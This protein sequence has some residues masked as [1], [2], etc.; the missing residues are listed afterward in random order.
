MFSSSCR[1]QLQLPLTIL[2]CA[3]GS[4]LAG[5]DQERITAGPSAEVPEPSVSA[6]GSSV[7]AGAWTT[8]APLPTP[9]SN[10]TAGVVND[11]LGQPILYVLGGRSP[12]I[13]Q[14]RVYAY[15]ATTNKWTE[16]A[17]MPGRRADMNGAATIKGMLY[18]SGGLNSVGGYTNTL[19]VY[20][21]KANAWATKAP[22]PNSVVN[23]I[24][25][26]L[27]DK[28]YV[29]YGAFYDGCAGCPSGFSQRLFRYDPATNTWKRMQGAPHK[30]AGGVGGVI[31]GKW[32]VAGGI[33][34]HLDVYDP[35]TNTWAT[36]AE[37]PP[38][39]RFTRRTVL[40]GGAVFA[41]RLYA[42]GTA[43]DLRGVWAYNPA[44]DKWNEEASLPNPRRFA[45]AAR[46]TRSGQ[47]I[48]L[49]GGGHDGTQALTTNEQYVR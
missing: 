19:F 33:D 21:P 30:H 47:P 32:Y 40:A 34:P 27:G 29:L 24:T 17:P 5:C 11:A 3:A 35:L 8:R 39:A 31:N 44:T 18:V 37:I 26:A 14:R 28:L 15:N 10:H 49:V 42:L 46:V 6:L 2:S 12:E 7:V 43:P 48:L 38:T 9:L 22:L 25:A 23:G 1:F 36:K 45:A 13:E 20:D 41:N 16:K 4:F